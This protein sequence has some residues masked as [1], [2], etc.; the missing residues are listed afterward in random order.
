MKC[1][2]IQQP[3]ASLIA[4]GI[5]D[6]ENRTDR[7]LVPPQHILIHV[8]AKSRCSLDEM[9]LAY[10]FPI[11]YAEQIGAFDPNSEN[12]RSAIIGYVDVVDIVTDSNSLWAQYSAEGE[13]PM[14][15]YILEN[16]KLFKNPILG[17]KGRLG[18][19]DI[20]EI[21]EN[22]LPETVELPNAER[23]GTQLLI[24]C[25]SQLW[26]DLS[27]W[28]NDYQDEETF[29][30]SLTLTD[31]NIDTLAPVNENEDI[32]LPDTIIF[33]SRNGATIEVSVLDGYT[34]ELC[35]EDS[36]EPIYYED[37]A[38]NEYVAM[39]VRFTVKRK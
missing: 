1:L 37:E 25:G 14:Q 15:H 27:A 19:W 35:Y 33:K 17:V 28:F 22:N 16:A 9:P 4:H 21:E 5:K 8:G 2:S 36:G 11:E 38:G 18:V 10:V 32:I 30:F 13:K 31:K 7:K 39:E 29:D 24:P 26:S 6:V 34:E 23:I 20:P 3:W 12:V